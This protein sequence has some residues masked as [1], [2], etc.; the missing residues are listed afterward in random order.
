MNPRF[1]R[2]WDAGGIILFILLCVLLFAVGSRLGF[3]R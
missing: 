2:W 3:W 1:G